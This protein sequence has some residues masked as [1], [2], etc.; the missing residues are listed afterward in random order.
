MRLHRQNPRVVTDKRLEML[1]NSMETLGDI[2]GILH[3]IQTDNIF[4]GNQRAK[5]IGLKEPTITKKYNPPTELGTCA[6]GYIEHDG[7]RFSFR[8]VDWDESKEKIAI[9]RA[10]KSA[11]E[12][13]MPMLANLFLELDSLENINTDLTGFELPEIERLMTFE[14]FQEPKEKPEPG[15]KKATMTNCPNCGVLI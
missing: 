11:G 4:G 6:E 9:I 2:S 12:N 8:Q 10:N 3:N 13:D 1:K 5:V 15:D 14:S 7:E